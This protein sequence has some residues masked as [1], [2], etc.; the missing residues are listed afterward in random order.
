MVQDVGKIDLGHG[1][2][3]SG[4]GVGGESSSKARIGGSCKLRAQVGS[5]PSSLIPSLPVAVCDGCRKGGALLV[6]AAQAQ[7]ETGREGKR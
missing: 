1:R 5:V 7:N 2:Y 6:K 4:V 3:E